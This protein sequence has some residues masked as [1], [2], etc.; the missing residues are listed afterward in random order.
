MST[1]GGACTR[2]VTYSYK[3]PVLG[4]PA[5]IIAS[6]I[7]SELPGHRALILRFAPPQAPKKASR[8]HS[9]F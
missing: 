2:Y 8:L 4:A 3:P 9:L 7:G 1:P 5:S 6:I